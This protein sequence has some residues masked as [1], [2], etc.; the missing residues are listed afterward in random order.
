MSNTS[1]FL[2]IRSRVSTAGNEEGLLGLAFHPNYA[3]NGHFY[4][5][6]SAA[7]PRRSVLSRFTVS[8]D[9][10]QAVS[11]SEHIVLEIPQPYSNHNGGMIEFGP[12]GFLYVGVG[13]GG[14]SDDPHG[15]GQNTTTLLGS[16]L[17]LDV[18]R[19]G[20]GKNYGIPASNPFASSGDTGGD[21]RPEIYAYGLRN[22]WRFSFD[23]ATGELWVGDVGQDK[24][25]EI[26]VV[27][28]GANYGWNTLEGFHCFSPSVGCDSSGTTYP[29]AEYDHSGRCSVTGGFVYRGA[30]IP[31]LHG[32]YIF[33]DFCS[34]EI[35]G[36]RTN[37]RTALPEL[38]ASGY[39]WS[40]SFGKDAHGN[41]YLLTLGGAIQ[42]ITLR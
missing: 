13:D 6:Y 27:E 32:V 39:K 11:S 19:T 35:W 16:I 3:K 14:S 29:V 30:A 15:H 21:P 4:V 17:R 31:S 24:W 28:N 40:P 23:S 10:N 9:P 1:T 25:E 20:D 37:D 34:G 8:D 36:I 26:D 41:I 42:R 38:I 33:G 5:Y 2:D 18:D 7:G 12:D 22:P